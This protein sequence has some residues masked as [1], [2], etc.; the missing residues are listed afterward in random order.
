MK[1]GV[2]GLGNIAQKAYLPIYAELR[3][4]ATFVLATRN[5]ETLREIST[6]YGFTET[7]ETVEDLIQAKVMA[8]FVHVATKVHGQ[9]V[10][11]LLEA[12]IHVFVDK[13]LSE[14]LNEVVE[15]QKIAEEKQLLLMV[16]FNRRFAP[17][18]QQ[19]KTVKEKNMLFI[20]KNRVATSH[21]SEFVIYDLFLHVVDTMVYLL[22]DPISSVKTKLV[23]ENGNLQR[24][25]LQVETPAITAIASMNLFAGANTETF[26]VIS[27]QGTYV[28]EELT[29]LTI[30]SAEIKQKE[31]FG[32]WVPTLEKRGFK[33]MVENFIQ[34]LHTKDSSK[35]KQENIFLSHEL[36]AKM[37]HDHQQHIL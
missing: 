6:K 5:Q 11:Q 34:A 13:P 32:D 9:I 1:I 10:K 26:Q 21:S 20:Q 19:L 36:C 7:V 30:K 37:L 2:L 25:L 14:N 24:A 33:Q 22:D 17:L 16:G 8:C 31:T 12:G 29:E 28:L 3:D 18:V 35:L 4:Q 15:I 23:E 27:K